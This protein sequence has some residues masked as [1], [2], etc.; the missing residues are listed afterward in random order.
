MSKKLAINENALKNDI[1]RKRVDASF[2]LIP[3]KEELLWIALIFVG[4][5][6]I[7][8]FIQRARL[9]FKVFDIECNDEQFENA[10]KMTREELKWSILTKQ[11]SYVRAAR[12]WDWSLSWGESITIKR[13]GR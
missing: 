9:R 13:K 5:A 12:R 4:L 3:T 8:F 1:I 2:E 6:F 11:K 7:S 10:L